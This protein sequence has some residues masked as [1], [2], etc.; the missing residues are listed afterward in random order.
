MA[1]VEDKKIIE[2][3]VKKIKPAPDHTRPSIILRGSK[4][5]NSKGKASSYGMS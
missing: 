4:D 1:K 3:Y 2:T 5:N